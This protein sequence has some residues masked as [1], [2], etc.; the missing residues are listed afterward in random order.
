M[1]HYARAIDNLIAD[2]NWYAI[3]ADYA[4]RYP[5]AFNQAVASI[6]Q[7]AWEDEAKRLLDA[8]QKIQAIKHC[9]AMTGMGLKQAKEAVE[10]LR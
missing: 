5:S 2:Q 6:N 9:R 8:E 7:P 4:K 3:A 1:N 10:A